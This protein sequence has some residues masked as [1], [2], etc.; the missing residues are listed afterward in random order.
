MSVLESFTEFS[1]AVRLDFISEEERQFLGLH[2]MDTM[3]AAIAGSH[4]PTVSSPS[5]SRLGS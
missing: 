2:L 3:G 4:T 5:G 1:A